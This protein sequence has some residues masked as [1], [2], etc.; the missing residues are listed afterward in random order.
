M[1]TN[2]H[3]RVAKTQWGPAGT[4][5]DGRGGE[6]VTLIPGDHLHFHRRNAFQN[7][8]DLLAV[9]ARKEAP[10]MLTE[11]QKPLEAEFQ[12]LMFK[13][14]LPSCP[15][16]SSLCKCVRRPALLTLNIM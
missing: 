3:V 8:L 6:A 5:R 7:L 16:L 11:G 14:H 2:E 12:P 4:A 15:R 10:G 13:C 1:H 9:K